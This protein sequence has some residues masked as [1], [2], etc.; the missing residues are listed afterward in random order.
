[1]KLL[2]P[3]IHGYISL[4]GQITG[5]FFSGAGTGAAF[6]F[7]CC[8]LILAITEALV[9]SAISSCVACSLAV[10]KIGRRWSKNVVN[11]TVKRVIILLHHIFNAS[12]MVPADRRSSS[13]ILY[14]INGLR[15]LF[16]Y[17]IACHFIPFSD[18]FLLCS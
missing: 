11:H 6:V 1:M 9:S 5:G 12:H 13:N 18:L 7:S 4:Q 3:V 16:L 15:N 17:R 10:T 8:S 2:C 14:R